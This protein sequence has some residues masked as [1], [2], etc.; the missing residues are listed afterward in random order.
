MLSD[1]ILAAL[2]EG[3]KSYEQLRGLVSNPD[4]AIGKLLRERKIIIYHGLSERPARFS[5]SLSLTEELVA[6]PQR[7]TL[8]LSKKRV[9]YGDSKVCKTCGQEKRI[10]QFG[11]SRRRELRKHTCSKCSKE[12]SKRGRSMTGCHAPS[13]ENVNGTTSAGR[14]SAGRSGDGA[15]HTG[16]VC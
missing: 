13:S 10:S 8:R 9:P 7:H 6:K 2:K 4:F 14:D 12:K 3:A 15:I 16:A 5:L 1:L 11:W